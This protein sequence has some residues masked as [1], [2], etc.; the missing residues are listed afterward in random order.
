MDESK[1]IPR[2]AADMNII[3]LLDNEPNDVGGMSAEALKAKHDEAGIILKDYINNTLLPA[4]AGEYGAENVGITTIGGLTGATNTQKALER[5][6]ELMQE[7]TQGAVA[8]ESIT[9]AKL[10]PKAVTTA[11]I[12]D[13]AI[14]TAQMAAKAV[15]N[16]KIAD[17][18]ITAAQLADAI[19]TAVK[20]A[21][22]AVGTAQI[23]DGA[24]TN[25]LLGAKAVGA[26]NMDDLS[27][28]TRALQASSVDASKIKDGVVSS[29]KLAANSVSA[30]YT[31]TIGTGWSG[32]AAP[33]TIAVTVTGIVASDTPMIDLNPSATFATAEKQIEAWG[34]VYRAVTAANKITFYATEKPEVSIPIKIKAV[35]K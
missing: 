28:P 29:A 35:R 31:A 17:K 12:D 15:T 32:T 2:L 21:N 25:P 16:A 10:A 8:N 1:L 19:I 11:K 9:T 22:K 30:N 6:V 20:I 34:Y 5:L 18:T 7:M 33:Y 23:A 14:G 3:A 27:V 13:G 26:A 4:F 24:I